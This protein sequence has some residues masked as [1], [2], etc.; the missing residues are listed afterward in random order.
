MET[1]EQSTDIT[2]A[3]LRDRVIEERGESFA[4]STIH[5]FFRRHGVSYKK[6]CAS[7]RTRA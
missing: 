4:L 2:L 5:G 1:I 3:E 7:K 6:D